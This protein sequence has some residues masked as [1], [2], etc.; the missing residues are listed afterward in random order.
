MAIIGDT[1]RFQVGFKGFDGKVIT[2][3]PDAV[4][5]KLYNSKRLELLTVT[6]NDTNKTST[7]HYHYDLTFGD[8]YAEDIYTFEFKG[9]F[10][11]VSYISRDEITLTFS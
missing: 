5:F 9:T 8:E 3:T 10:N 6:L 1:V 11:E 4:H 7:G 2:D